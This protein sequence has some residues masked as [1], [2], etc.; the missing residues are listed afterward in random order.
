MAPLLE[1]AIQVLLGSATTNELSPAVRAGYNH[2][3][4]NTVA[5]KSLGGIGLSSVSWGFNRMDVFAI[6]SHGDVQH[7]YWDG[8]QWRPSVTDLESL[9]GE[10]ATSPAAVSW[11]SD[12]L[13]IFNV[14]KDGNLYHQYW[15]G[16]SWQPSFKSWESLGTNLNTSH[17]LAVTAWGSNRL[18]VFGIGSDDSGRDALWHKYWDGSSWHPDGSG[19]ESLGGELVSGPAATS[20]GKGR[21]DIFALNKHGDLMHK[22]W[23]GSNWIGWERIGE[24]FSSTPTV[25]SWGEN[26]LD[27]F[28][29]RSDSKLYHKYWD[30]SQWSDWEDFGGPLHGTVAATSWGPNRIDIVGWGRDD[31][32]YHYKYWDGHQWN[33]SAEGWS[34]KAGKFV[35]S[36][37]VVSW[38]QD[39]LD[40]YGIWDDNQLAHQTWYGTGWYPEYAEWE[41]LGGSLTTFS[42]EDSE[43][44]RSAMK[45]D[46]KKG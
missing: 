12:R 28:G 37:S 26:R 39:R 41:K 31:G 33:P 1:L 42:P 5:T 22:F 18:D 13:D 2:L 25:T 7:K 3:A 36:P 24:D 14:G 21:L 38:G 20:W 43:E 29:I 40:I 34:S 30:G 16:K 32:H 23:D 46:L 6:G 44:E 11:G 19:L 15:D 17:P 27:V 45:L 10:A 35:S 8:Y 4:E 9:G